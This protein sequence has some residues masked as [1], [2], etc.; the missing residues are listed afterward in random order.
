MS[1]PE[2]VGRIIKKD[3]KDYACVKDQ[4]EYYYFIRQSQ[5]LLLTRGKYIKSDRGRI[6]KL[7]KKYP[8]AGIFTSGE[9]LSYDDILRLK[10][11]RYDLVRD[12]FRGDIEN[13]GNV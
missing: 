1:Y 9:I 7:Q 8:V 5:S 2:G 11:K 6:V 12:H 4:G 10:P 13:M 3:L